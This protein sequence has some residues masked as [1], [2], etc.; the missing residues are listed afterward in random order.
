MQRR[1]QPCRIRCHP[2]LLQPI[3]DRALR[4]QQALVSAWKLEGR[5]DACSLPRSCTSPVLTPEFLKSLQ[6]LR[7]HQHWANLLPD[8][9]GHHPSRAIHMFELLKCG[10]CHLLPASRRA[11]PLQ[12]HNT[13]AAVRSRE[14]RQEYLYR[15]GLYLTTDDVVRWKRSSP[16]HPRN[17]KRAR[18][19][20]DVGLII[21]LDF[22][23]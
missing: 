20:Y 16:D 3:R 8:L 11:P 12:Q 18:K 9:L 13:V 15:H 19:A 4:V 14:E 23:A 7:L 10:P 17:W 6:D 22:W 21:L 5:L 2:R 1:H